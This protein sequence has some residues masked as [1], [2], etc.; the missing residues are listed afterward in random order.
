MYEEGIS[1]C[2]SKGEDHALAE[3]LSAKTNAEID[4]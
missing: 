3:L 4:F 1:V 2:K